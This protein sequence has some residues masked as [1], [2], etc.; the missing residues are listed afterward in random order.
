MDFV[1]CQVFFSTFSNFFV[2][3]EGGAMRT[4]ATRLSLLY[5]PC[6]S[7][8]R[9]NYIIAEF[10]LRV[11]HYFQSILY[12]IG[13]AGRGY[14]ARLEGRG[15]CYLSPSSNSA[16]FS[17]FLCW[18]THSAKICASISTSASPVCSSSKVTSSV[19][20]RQIISAVLRTCGVAWLVM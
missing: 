15:R 20:Y 7:L 2:R 19:R 8:P 16:S 9:N 6:S 4:C 13:R 5:S 17:I 14:M 12:T 1:V 11:K 3:W 10:L 18:R